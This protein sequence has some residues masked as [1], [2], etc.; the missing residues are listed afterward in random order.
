MK[1]FKYIFLFVFALGFMSCEE[2]LSE[3]P[4]KSSNI[5][6]KTIADMETIL[7]GIWRSDCISSHILFASDDVHFMPEL[8]LAKNGTY[9]MEYVMA[10]TW[11]RQE[12]GKMFKDYMW[13]YR[14]QNIFRSNLVLSIIPNIVA[15][16]AELARIKAKA[17]FRRAYSYMEL[18]NIYTLPYSEK[19]LNEMGLV[20]NQSTSFSSSLK[21]AT[22][23]ETYAFIEKDIQEALK[24]DISLTNKFGQG[25]RVRVTKAAANALAA[26]FYLIKHDYANAKKYAQASLDDYGVSNIMNYNQ[27]LSYHTKED[28]GT[29]EIDGEKVDYVVKYPNTYS[30]YDFVNN[31]TEDIFTGS[32]SSAFS[33]G[34]SITNLPSRS[35]IDCYGADGDSEKD[36]RWKYFFV[37]NFLYFKGYPVDHP[38]FYKTAYTDY[39]ITV[40]EVLLMVAECEARAGDYNEAIRL[41]NSLRVKRIEP[42]GKVM[43]TAANKDEAIAIVLRERRRELCITARL[44]DLRRYNSND[45]AADD[46]VVKREFFAYNTSA[47][48]L[49]APLKTYELKTDDRRYA[50]V[51]P[52]GDILAGKGELLQNTY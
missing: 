23:E 16:D 20:L 44:F 37:D 12:I 21:R 43:L 2:F 13:M 36:C 50:V 3:R 34:M 31:W 48:D 7:A 30:G 39:N 14:Y 4:S 35:L 41:V 27:A 40:P 25:S 1:R 22:L 38:Y 32:V 26:R 51:I 5:V 19:N 9:N 11:E 17:C 46:V 8:E 10:G 47:L 52:E 15:S 6:P 42:D 49:T 33:S 28:K 29:V 45:Y 18:L 24:I